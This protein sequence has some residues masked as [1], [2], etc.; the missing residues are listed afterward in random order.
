MTLRSVLLSIQM[1]LSAPEPS[2]PQD[3]VVARQYLNNK[4]MFLVRNLICF[5]QLIILLKLI[6][7]YFLLLIFFQQTARFWSQYYAKAPGSR[8]EDFDTKIERLIEMGAAKVN[9]FRSVVSEF[10]FS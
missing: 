1:L 2:D 4:K 8:S 9:H 5:F 6:F 3:A 7:F 10:I